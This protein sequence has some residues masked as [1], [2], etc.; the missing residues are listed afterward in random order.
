MRQPSHGGVRPSWVQHR[1]RVQTPSAGGSVL[2]VMGVLDVMRARGRRD[3]TK[4]DA[5]AV[6]APPKRQCRPDTA[7]VRYLP[8]GA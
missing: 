2:D 3:G 6:P 8:V 7:A 4:Q 5:G 1:G